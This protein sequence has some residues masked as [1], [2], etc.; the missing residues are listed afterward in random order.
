[1]VKYFA[2]GS[3]MSDE[4]IR[5]RCPSHKFVCVAELRDY[6]LAFTRYSHKRSCGVADVVVAPGESVWGA[7][8]EMP[9]SDMAALDV[10]EGVHS[11]PPA[12]A[13]RP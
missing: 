3:N 7:V 9:E 5:E 4:Q 13:R 11:K 12:Y 8:F 10:H 1:M 6:K 2:Y